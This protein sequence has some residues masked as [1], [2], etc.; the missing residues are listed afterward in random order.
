MESEK[1]R[2]ISIDI[3]LLGCFFTSIKTDKYIA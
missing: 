2:N 3:I 1:K